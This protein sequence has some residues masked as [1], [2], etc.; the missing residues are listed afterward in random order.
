MFRSSIYPAE[1]VMAADRT[2]FHKQCI[3][4]KICSKPL[5]SATMNEHGSQ[6]YCKA[7]YDGLF[8]AHVRS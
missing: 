6:L 4:C 1:L 7:C 2:P 3:K 8:D 5:N